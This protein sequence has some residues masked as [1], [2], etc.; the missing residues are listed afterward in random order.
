MLAK[1]ISDEIGALSFEILVL[2]PPASSEQNRE[3]THNSGETFQIYQQSIVKDSN[4]WGLL[5][6]KLDC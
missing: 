3:T 2:N 4:N 5:L 6:A 1:N